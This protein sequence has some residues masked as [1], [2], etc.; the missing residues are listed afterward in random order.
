MHC[1]KSPHVIYDHIIVGR[2][3][4]RPYQIEILTTYAHTIINTQTPYE[5]HCEYVVRDGPQKYGMRLQLQL[6]FM[7]I[8]S[9]L[10]W[11]AHLEN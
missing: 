3:C 11:A 4:V 9:T 5:Y 2:F 8:I 7:F 6:E 1:M 10:K